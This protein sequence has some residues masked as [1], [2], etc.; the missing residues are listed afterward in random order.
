MPNE[1][2]K[3]VLGVLMEQLLLCL[4]LNQKEITGTWYG[5][6]GWASLCVSMCVYFL[7]VGVGYLSHNEASR[8][9]ILRTIF[10]NFPSG[11]EAGSKVFG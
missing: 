2:F 1:T 4:C 3:L 9:Q 11:S 6:E 7:R 10:E 8:S 5:R